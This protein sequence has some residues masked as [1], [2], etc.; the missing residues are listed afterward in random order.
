MHQPHNHLSHENGHKVLQMTADGDPNEGTNDAAG[1][2][3]VKPPFHGAGG[4]SVCT[5]CYNVF[6]NAKTLTRH[7]MRFHGTNP[8]LAF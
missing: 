2:A 1:Q 8:S 4:Y 5:V 6:K 3:N 7:M